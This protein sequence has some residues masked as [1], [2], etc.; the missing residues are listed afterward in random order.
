MR[1]VP[2]PSADGAGRTDSP[3]F[4][5]VRHFLGE[6]RRALVRCYANALKSNPDARGT[7]GF[8]VTFS[9]EGRVTRVDVVRRDGAFSDDLTACV[10]RVL[11]GL[12]IGPGDGP[13]EIVI[14]LVLTTDMWGT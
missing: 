11:A 6:T 4:D 12:S 7:I 10:S 5:E 8:R 9:T 1:R 2:G 3:P 13:R 14:P